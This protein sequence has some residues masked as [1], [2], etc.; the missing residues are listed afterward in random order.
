MDSK[1]SQEWI[2]VGIT[3]EFKIRK[4]LEQRRSQAEA[5]LQRYPNKVPVVVEEVAE[6]STFAP[7][8]NRK[9]M[10]PR[11]LTAGQFYYML[12]QRLRLASEET[13]F[14]Y[15]G[16]YLPRA[17]DALGCVYDRFHDED[18]FLYAAYSPTEEMEGPKVV[19]VPKAHS[20][21]APP[22][23]P[24]TPDEHERESEWEERDRPPDRA[25]DRTPDRQ[26]DR[27]RSSTSDRAPARDRERSGG[28]RRGS[29]T[30]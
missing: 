14:V 15:L 23:T 26:P 29:R 1:E 21:A 4:T 19:A 11:Q 24:T 25:S 5:E 22:S 17:T 20:P 7:L 13:L 27:K 6:E 18:G 30:R 28:V 2:L 8:P 3:Y 12:R 16:G 10:V 9:F